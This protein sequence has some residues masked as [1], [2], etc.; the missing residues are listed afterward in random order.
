[1]P[2]R[3]LLTSSSSIICLV[4]AVV[5]FRRMEPWWISKSALRIWN[6]RSRKTAGIGKTP[7]TII[8]RPIAITQS[9][10]T[11]DTVFDCKLIKTL[12]LMCLCQA[13]EKWI[14]IYQFFLVCIVRWCIQCQTYNRRDQDASHYHRSNVSPSPLPIPTGTISGHLINIF[15][16]SNEE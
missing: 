2:I 6:R 8:A 13:D 4:D 10:Y 11:V 7:A 9:G 5:S 12:L 3:L 15:S 16:E 1:M 14:E